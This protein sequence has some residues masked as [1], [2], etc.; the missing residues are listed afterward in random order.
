MNHNCGKAKFV[1]LAPR[2]LTL[3]VEELALVYTHAD[4]FAPPRCTIENWMAAVLLQVMR[5]EVENEKSKRGKS[6]GVHTSDV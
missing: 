6:D 1:R 4:L 3:T 5:Q 2:R